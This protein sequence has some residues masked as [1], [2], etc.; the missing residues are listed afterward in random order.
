MR[1]GLNGSGA[2]KEGRLA[3]AASGMAGFVQRTRPSSVALHE[4]R[5][6]GDP[7]RAQL[8]RV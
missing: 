7:A 6:K 5:R 1:R 2:S 3:A 8:R 4:T